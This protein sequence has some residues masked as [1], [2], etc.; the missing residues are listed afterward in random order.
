MWTVLFLLFV[1]LRVVVILLSRLF[2]GFTFFL[3]IL[4]LLSWWLGFDNDTGCTFRCGIFRLHFYFI[5]GCLLADD[6]KFIWMLGI[7]IWLFGQVLDICCFC[8]GL[9]CRFVHLGCIFRC[10]KIVKATVVFSFIGIRS[11]VFN[12]ITVWILLS[13]VTFDWLEFILRF[14]SSHSGILLFLYAIFVR[15]VHHTLVHWV[16]VILRTWLWI[17]NFVL[18]ALVLCYILFT[19]L[20]TDFT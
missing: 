10:C 13:F 17:I 3:V 12:I 18:R 6:F 2:L 7:A 9:G 19:I 16:W 20:F 11:I 8:H 15:L 1:W 4:N 14:S 5:R